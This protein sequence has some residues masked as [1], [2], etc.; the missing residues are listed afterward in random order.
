[1]SKLNL[2]KSLLHETDLEKLQLRFLVSLIEIQNVERGSVWIKEDDHYLCREAVGKESSKIKNIRLSPHKKSIVGWVIENKKMTIADPRNDERCCREIEDRLDTKNTFLLCFPLIHENNEMYGAIEILDTSPESDIKNIDQ[3]HLTQIQEIVD[4]GSLA[5]GNAMRYNEQKKKT[6]QL[7]QIL[8]GIREEN[9]MI[10]QSPTLQ[11][12]MKSVCNY[13]QIDKP[14]LITGEHGTEK[15]FIATRVYRESKRKDKPFCIVNCNIMPDFLVYRELFGR[16]KDDTETPGI[17]ESMNGGTVFLNGIESLPPDVQSA[18]SELI[19]NRTVRQEGAEDS[20][21]VDIRIIAGTAA[22][23]EKAVRQ[24][25]FIR[26]LFRRFSILTLELPPIREREEYASSLINYFLRKGSL[27]MNIPGKKIS[28]HAL[29]LLN[30]YTWPGNTMEVKTFS[31]QLLNISTEGEYISYEDI[32]KYFKKMSLP[33]PD[34][35]NV[36]NGKSLNSIPFH[37][38]SW[39]ELER[40]YVLYTLKKNNGNITRAAKDARINRSTFVSRMKRLN[41]SKPDYEQNFSD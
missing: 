1:M 11:N 25:K 33:I 24:K 8:N 18:I 4:I 22:D 38:Y 32:L 7:Q 34:S 28:K 14:V 9:A 29:E 5:L 36:V 27:E 30:S 37:K 12:I 21:P 20:K 2:F 10:K 26:E 3:A 19:E 23:L 15:E 17:F 6:E 40:E 41:L 35:A 13:A 16:K 31:N 39:E